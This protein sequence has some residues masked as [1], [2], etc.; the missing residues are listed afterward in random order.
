MLQD[1]VAKLTSA[2][3]AFH[4]WI[5]ESSGNPLM[6]EML[7]LYWHH[8]RRSMVAVVEPAHERRRVWEEHRAVL[9]AVLAGDEELAAK[10][11]LQHIKD[12]AERVLQRLP[13]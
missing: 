9:E 13:E 1:S 12:A 8:L 6:A 4:M 3:M 11:S 10:L 7:K 5:Y 2:D